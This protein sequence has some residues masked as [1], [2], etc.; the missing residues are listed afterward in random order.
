MFAKIDLRNLLH[1]LD[2]RCDPHAQ[3]EIRVYAEAMRELATKIAP[4]AM[5]A[6]ASE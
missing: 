4:V 5:G 3:Q 1:F 6:W 2:L